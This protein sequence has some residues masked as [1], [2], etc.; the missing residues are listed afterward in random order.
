MAISNSSCGKNDNLRFRFAGEI[1]YDMINNLFKMCPTKCVTG[2]G[3]Y[4]ITSYIQGLDI[5]SAFRYHAHWLCGGVIQYIASSK[6][7]I[8]GI[9]VRHIILYQVYRLSTRTITEYIYTYTDN[10]K[11]IQA[12]DYRRLLS[13]TQGSTRQQQQQ[14]L[15]INSI[16]HTYRS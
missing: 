6:Y 1:S 16:Y 12:R 2:D 15:L 4:D 13:R 8:P 3:G 9:P 10:M 11:K 14:L 5:R 7:H